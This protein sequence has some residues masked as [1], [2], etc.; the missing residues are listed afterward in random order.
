MRRHEAQVHLPV[1][2]ITGSWSKRC[3]VTLMTIITG[4]R[5]IRS[6]KLMAL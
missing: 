6:R 5:L 3:D 2:A 4:K 1:T